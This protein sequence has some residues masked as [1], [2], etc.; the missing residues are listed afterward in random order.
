[1]KIIVHSRLN[2]IKSFFLINYNKYNFECF[3][4][5]LNYIKFKIQI[6]FN[7]LFFKKFAIFLYLSNV[8]VLITF[9]LTTKRDVE[10][11]NIMNN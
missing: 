5:K 1:M 11:V 6:N 9:I 8:V 3:I 2:S 10:N 7:I 4:E